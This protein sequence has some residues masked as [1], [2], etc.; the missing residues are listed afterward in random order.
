MNPDNLISKSI[1]TDA[2]SV[3]STLR[4]MIVNGTYAAGERLVEIPV[5]QALGVSRTP[6][7]LALRT[8]EQEG[9]LEKSGAR[10]V[11]VRS[12]SHEDVLCAVEVRGVLE[13]LAARRLAERGMGDA[14][15]SALQTCLADGDVV[16]AKG[17]LASEDLKPWSELNECFHS[18]ILEATGTRIISDAI[19]RNN[20]LPLASSDAIAIDPQ[21]MN[22]EYKKL[23]VAQMQH[24]LVF[25]AL[26][27]G[28][29]ARAEMLMR[30][31]AYIGLR[32]GQLFRTQVR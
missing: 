5:A 16:L 28:E 22:R 21:N 1:A 8:L 10:G 15:R 24:R 7:R 2:T 12:F 25:E 3:V 11:V 23:W 19:A 26:S 27:N 20:A 29:S 14:V 30:E 17:T 13:G 6:V 18:T 32:Y 9:L 31:H 4:T